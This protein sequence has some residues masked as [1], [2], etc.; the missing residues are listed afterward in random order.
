M[1]QWADSPVRTAEE[2]DRDLD[3]LHSIWA[4]HPGFWGWLT[5]VDHKRIG[6]LYGIESDIRGRPP[7]HHGERHLLDRGEAP[8]ALRARVHARRLDAVLGTTLVAAGLRGLFLGDGHGN[9]GV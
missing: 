4:D 5:T 8:A 3:H 9:G 2:R 1:M 7:D 6:Q